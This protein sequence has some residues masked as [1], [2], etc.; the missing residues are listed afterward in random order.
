MLGMSAAISQSVDREIFPEQVSIDHNQAVKSFSG[1]FVTMSASTLS[2]NN[3]PPEVSVQTAIVNQFGMENMVLLKQSGELNYANITTRG[4]LNEVEWIQDGMRNWVSI[5]LDGTNYDVTGKQ[6]GN[7]NELR[8]DYEGA[9]VEQSFLQDG[10]RLF[11]EFSGV[12]TPMTVT[13][14]GDGAAIIIK[15]Q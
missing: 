3:E 15:N 12:P 8:L 10:N 4:D 7:Y 13:Q 14:R 6:D 5:K 2:E 1:D 11:L 9:G